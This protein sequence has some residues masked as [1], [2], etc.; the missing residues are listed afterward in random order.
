M[1]EIFKQAKILKEIILFVL[2]VLE[3]MLF[4]KLFLLT[5]LFIYYQVHFTIK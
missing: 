3:K 1:V 2:Y 5:Y 4:L